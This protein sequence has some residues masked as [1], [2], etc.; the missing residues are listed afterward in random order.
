MLLWGPLA[1]DS[2]S[3]KDTFYMKM[4]IFYLSMFQKVGVP[5]PPLPPA[6]SPCK[7]P[8]VF[9]HLEHVVSVLFFQS[10][11]MAIVVYG[12]A[13]ALE[14]GNFTVVNILSFSLFQKA[15]LGKVKL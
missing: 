5:W 14:A 12:P 2:Y 9:L 1:E 13:I 4:Y 8:G 7:G 15:P 6:P 11:Y 3:S 10:L